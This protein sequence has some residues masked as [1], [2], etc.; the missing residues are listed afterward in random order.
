MSR[1]YELVNLNKQ[2]MFNVTLDNQ[3]IIRQI[4]EAK[5]TVT[6]NKTRRNQTT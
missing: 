3:S 4:Q 6:K 2:I 1:V 5:C